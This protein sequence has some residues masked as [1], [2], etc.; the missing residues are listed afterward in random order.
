MKVFLVCSKDVDEWACTEDLPEY[1]L[2]DCYLTKQEAEDVI[3]ELGNNPNH[4]VK[5]AEGYSL[6][7]I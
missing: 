6:G 3:I 1:S 4:F 7:A 5:E 2:Y